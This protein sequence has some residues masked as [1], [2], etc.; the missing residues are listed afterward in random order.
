MERDFRARMAG[1]RVEN[2]LAIAESTAED[3]FEPEAIEAARTELARREIDPQDLSDLKE[4]QKII[5]YEAHERSEIPLSNIAWIGFALTGPIL[6][7]TAPIALSFLAQGY[8]K[9]SKHAFSG[10]LAGFFLWGVGIPFLLFTL[11]WLGI[12]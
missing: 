5:S 7:L 3:G 6:L 4:N 12:A 8:K 11:H 1:E 10:I 9:K 2:L